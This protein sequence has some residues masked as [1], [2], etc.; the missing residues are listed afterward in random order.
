MADRLLVFVVLAFLVAFIVLGGPKGCQ[1]SL[2]RSQPEL[3]TALV[4]KVGIPAQYRGH[5][6]LVERIETVRD[7][8]SGTQH[9]VCLRVDGRPVLLDPGGPFYILAWVNRSFAFY[10]D[11]ETKLVLNRTSPDHTE[12]EWAEV[13]AGWTEESAGAGKR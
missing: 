5:V 2:E 7:F 12:L 10:L 3:P 6:V 11:P 9:R 13:P 1:E 8:F 4:T